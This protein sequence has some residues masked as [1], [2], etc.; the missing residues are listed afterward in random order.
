MLNRL[1]SR[2]TR[3]LFIFLA[4]LFSTHLFLN[5]SFAHDN[6]YVHPYITEQAFK[7]WPNDQNHEF[8][9]YLGQGLRLPDCDPLDVACNVFMCPL[10]HDGGVITEGAKEEDDYDTVTDICSNA[11]LPSFG[12][13]FA[14]H[15]YDPDMPEPNNGLD[16]GF[17]NEYG[18][19]TYAKI[20]WQTAK[21]FYSSGNKGMAYWYLGKISHLL[22]DASV[23]AHV[24]GDPHPPVVNGDS[25]EDYMKTNCHYAN[26]KWTDD[27]RNL[28]ALS[29]ITLDT[30]FYTLA[31]KTQYFPSNDRVGNTD[32]ADLNWFSGWPSNPNEMRVDLL[33]VPCV[34]GSQGCHIEDANLIQIANKLMPLAIQATAKLYEMFYQQFQPTISASTSYMHALQQ[35]VQLTGGG[36]IDGVQPEQWEWDFDYNGNPADFNPSGVQGK[37]VTIPD[38]VLLGSYKTSSTIT[39]KI[40]LR[41]SAAGHDS[42]IATYDITIRPYPFNIAYHNGNYESHK[43][44]CSTETSSFVE[45]NSDYMWNFGDN[46]GTATGPTAPEYEYA[47]SGF[48][49]ITLTL[50]LKDGTTLTSQIERYFGPGPRYIQG[51]TI[52]GDETWYSGGTYEVQGNISVAQGASLTIEHGVTV[53]IATGVSFQVYGTLKATGATFTWADGQNQWNGIRF[54]G[55]ASSNSKLDN[56]IIEHASGTYG[57]S[58]QVYNLVVIYIESASPTINGCTLRNNSASS[59][60]YIFDSGGQS[61]P[62]LTNNIISGF[63]S[64]IGIS[65]DAD[66]FFPATTSTPTITGNTI[67]GNSIGI[68]TKGGGVYQ[69]NNF[70]NN[71]VGI[72]ASYPSNNNPDILNNTYSSNTNDVELSGTIGKS[73]NWNN[74][75]SISTYGFT[76]ASGGNVNISNGAT[77]KLFQ[78]ASIVVYGTLKATGATF[79][80]ADG[81]NQW[82]GIRFAGAASSNSK[83]DNCIIEHASGTYGYSHQVYNLV[84]I[85][86]ESASPTINGCMLRNNSASSVIYIFDSGGQSAPML[87]NNIISGFSSGIGISIDADYFFPATTSTPTITGNTITGNDYGIVTRGGG[88]YQ[89]NTI[90]NN[91]SFG[92]YYSGS[93]I[94]LAT[95]NNWGDPSGPLD[96]SDDRASGGLYNPNGKGNRVSDN[97]NYYPWTGTTIAAPV[98]PTS[99]SGIPSMNSVNLKW[100]AGS[101]SSA[102]GFKVYYGT[103][104]GTYGTPQI[105]GNVSKYKL[106]GLNN[107]TPYFITVSAMNAVGAESDKSNEITEKP[108]NKYLLNVSFTGDGHGNVLSDPTGIAGNVETYALFDPNTPV[109]LTGTASEYSLFKGWTG[110]YTAESGDCL[111]TMDSDKD[112]TAKFNEDKDH[113]T[114]IYGTSDYNDTILKAYTAATTTNYIIQAWGTDFI[115]TLNLNLPKAVILKGGFNQGYSSNSGKSTLKGTLTIT[116]GSLTV[117]NVQI[118]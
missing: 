56:C 52:Y 50:N 4:I 18:A 19:L 101:G 105:V 79:T 38:E 61:A 11:L 14:H 102:G 22:A 65:I 96:D 48:Y 110:D 20:Y 7:I 60:I 12:Y 70:N 26:Q 35:G 31:Q 3:N 43:I 90:S 29:S 46:T 30:L 115:E 24:H 16:V 55:A 85:Y 21:D 111:L 109:K 106:T 73:L 1:A 53:K 44:T 93:N 88:A 5:P 27:A 62:M 37:N 74:V 82:N 10:A 72:S 86:I 66:Y 63:S 76:I 69:S 103:S 33:G 59:V 6:V 57:Y 71:V 78:G 68:M 87:T 47:T 8:F 107:D 117:E 17:G 58:H 23:P 108:L 25:Y 13:A 81:Q 113:R 94:L 41:V 92:I 77:F 2:R 54:A 114:L 91:I 112:V 116:S 89:Q 40:G 118:Q 95:N 104:A 75:S 15:F 84:V 42:K 45:H 49:P 9:A 83:L 80:W 97:V 28:P 32:N 34:Y 99:L 51:H 67:T 39:K 98:V 64:G 36:S 100:T